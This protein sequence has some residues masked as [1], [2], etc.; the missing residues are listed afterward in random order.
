MS[1]GAMSIRLNIALG[2]NRP[3]DAVF[4][5]KCGLLLIWYGHNI[6][7]EPPAD[8]VPRVLS[9]ALIVLGFL[10]FVLSHLNVLGK[11][12]S[13]NAEILAE[14]KNIGAHACVR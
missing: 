4:I 3:R 1:L 9:L 10:V 14:F 2:T 8:E 6:F 7:P 13:N 12:F 5:T 11:I